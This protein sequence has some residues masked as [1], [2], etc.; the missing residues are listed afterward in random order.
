MDKFPAS[1]EFTSL[2]TCTNCKDANE[3]DAG[4]FMQR[5]LESLSPQRRRFV[6]GQNMSAFRILLKDHTEMADLCHP[7]CALEAF[8]KGKVAETSL[9]EFFKSEL[10]FGDPL[11]DHIRCV[12][13]ETAPKAPTWVISSGPWDGLSGGPLEEWDTHEI[14][15]P[16]GMFCSTTCFVAGMA[17]E[18]RRMKRKHLGRWYKPAPLGEFTDL[19][20]RPST[21][22]NAHEVA[23]SKILKHGRKEERLPIPRILTMI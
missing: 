9:E 12:H 13:C 6:P 5:W 14:Y 16:G 20:E 15:V 7:A 21:R 18:I 22:P 2:V 3:S 17:A 19:F 4:K 1:M 10:L 23:S 8:R 11:R